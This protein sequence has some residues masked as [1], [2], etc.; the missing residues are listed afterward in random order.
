M[1][2]HWGA[3]NASDGIA[4]A[5]VSGNQVVEA[6]KMVATI[7]TIGLAIPENT[8]QD[9]EQIGREGK[10]IIAVRALKAARVAVILTGSEQARG[11]LEKSLTPPI[12]GTCRGIGSEGR[13][14]RVCRA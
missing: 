10:S 1:T 3:V 4:V 8:L 2:K 9:V 7:K 12:Q 14:T 13:F 6:K 5:T 11:R